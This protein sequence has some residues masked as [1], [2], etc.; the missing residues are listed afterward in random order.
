[1]ALELIYLSLKMHRFPE[2]HKR[3]D[4]FCPCQSSADCITIMFG[5][6]FQQGQV[7]STQLME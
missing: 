7:A 1:M 5:S 4:P 6:D 2:P 3:R